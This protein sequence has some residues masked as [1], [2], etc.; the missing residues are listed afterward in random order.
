MKETDRE[1]RTQRK[2][3]GREGEREG[4]VKESE[5]ERGT[6][7]RQRGRGGREG[8]REGEGNAKRIEGEAERAGPCVEVRARGE[9]CEKLLNEPDSEEDW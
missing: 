7:R 6:R 3:K 4:T 8:G 9:P 1:R 2:Q 5:R